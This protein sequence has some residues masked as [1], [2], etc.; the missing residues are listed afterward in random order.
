LLFINVLPSSSSSVCFPSVKVTT[1]AAAAHDQASSGSSS[2]TVDAAAASACLSPA[3]AG[4]RALDIVSVLGGETV[5]HAYFC[6]QQ[7]CVQLREL[8]SPMINYIFL[9][10]C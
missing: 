7:V 8:F 5:M 9:I 4:A 1:T 6:S 2:A 3:H 10:F